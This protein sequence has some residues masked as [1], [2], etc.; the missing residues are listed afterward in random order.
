MPS[1]TFGHG[2]QAGLGGRAAGGLVFPLRSG[3]VLQRLFA[4]E[5][6]PAAPALASAE[7]PC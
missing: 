4:K 1:R 7:M 5:G 3:I 6:K 2:N